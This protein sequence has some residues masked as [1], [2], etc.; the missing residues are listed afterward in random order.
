MQHFLFGLWL[1]NKKK[2]NPDLST[3]LQNARLLTEFFF[4]FNAHIINNTWST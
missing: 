3:F 1:K 4:F 2:K